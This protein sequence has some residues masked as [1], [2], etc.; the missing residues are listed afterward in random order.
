MCAEGQEAHLRIKGCVFVCV[1]V[2]LGVCV[3]VFSKLAQ[4]C[5]VARLCY[6]SNLRALKMSW[7]SGIMRCEPFVKIEAMGGRVH[8]L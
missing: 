4:H 1:C 8:A 7:S 5:W 3:C 2:C 6:F